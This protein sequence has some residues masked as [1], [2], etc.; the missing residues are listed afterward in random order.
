MEQMPRASCYNPMSKTDAG[1]DK[2]RLPLCEL[3]TDLPQAPA[4]SRRQVRALCI[5]N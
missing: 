1:R 5:E 4:L 3:G 2:G